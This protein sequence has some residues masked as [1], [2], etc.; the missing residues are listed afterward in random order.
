MYIHPAFLFHSATSGTKRGTH[1]SNDQLDKI[2]VTNS[3][4]DPHKNWMVR[5]FPRALGF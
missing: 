5:C 3:Q 4:A 2:P 1:L